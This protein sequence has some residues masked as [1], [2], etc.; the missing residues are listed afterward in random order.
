M[1]NIS[2]II[3]AAGISQRMGQGI[4]K[5]YLLLTRKPIL[6]HIIETFIGVPGVKEIIIAI[7]PEDRNRVN[8]IISGIKYGV[9]VVLGGPERQD[10]VANALRKVSPEAE[11]VLIHDAARPFIR[12]PDIIRL[13]REV[14]RSGAAILGM[15]VAD[16]IKRVSQKTGFIKE[17]I[18]PREELYQAQTPQ[19]F[20][21]G[22]IM[23]AYHYAGSRHLKATDDAV[24]VEKAGY[25]VRVIRCIYE[26]SKI[27]TKRDMISRGSVETI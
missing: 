17:T 2:V 1:T 12:R 8:K 21:K 9:K 20:K 23:A 16:T 10:S 6:L 5:P 7:H 22:I 15:P 14:K 24:L 13:I 3:P 25:P 26:N 19:G 27:T 11:I 4:H 18:I